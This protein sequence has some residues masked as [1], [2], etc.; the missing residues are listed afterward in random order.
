MGA[1]VA[2]TPEGLRDPLHGDPGGP[3]PTEEKSIGQFVVSPAGGVLQPGQSMGVEVKFLP[4]ESN[5][6]RE[7]LKIMISGCEAG[8][9]NIANASVYECIGESCFPGIVSDDWRSIFEEQTVISSMSDLKLSSKKGGIGKAV[10]AEDDVLFGYGNVISSSVEQ[11]KGTVEKFRITNPTKVNASVAFSLVPS[12]SKS[13]TNSEGDVAAFT[14][15][16]AHWEIPPHEYRYV[17]VYFRPMEMRSYRAQFQAKVA[18]A[19]PS[20]ETGAGVGSKMAFDLSGAGTLPCVNVSMPNTNNAGGDLLMA[21]GSVEHGKTKKLQIHVS[22]DGVVPCTVLF[23]MGDNSLNCF[24]FSKANGSETME[25]GESR[26]LHVVFRPNSKLLE[27]K[28]DISTTIKMS[29]MHNNFESETLLLSGSTYS[30]DALIEDIPED[31]LSFSEVDLNNTDSAKLK[32]EISFSLRSQ[33]D[34]PLRFEFTKHEHFVFVPSVGHLPAG[35]TRDIVGVFSTNGEVKAYK[36]EEVSKRS[37]AS[38]P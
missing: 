26:Q 28:E 35:S 6:F 31:G 14:V 15:Q 24:E 18:D 11:E 13:A 37:E 38:E 22:N 3:V 32:S 5:V 29:V 23:S 34:S 8:D 2:A 25:P 10:F 1:I 17:S 36:A 12:G 9:N 21:F 7:N 33:S 19:H 4:K 20:Q 16:P 30:N 27:S